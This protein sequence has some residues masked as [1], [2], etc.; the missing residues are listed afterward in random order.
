MFPESIDPA[1]ATTAF[2]VSIVTLV[3]SALA[4][5]IVVVRL[6]ADYFVA[7]RRTHAPRNGNALL[8]G[9]LLAL[10]SLLGA[11][12]VLLGIVMLVLPGQG[13][14]M[15]IAG[16]SLMRFPGK[17]KLLRRLLGAPGVRRV[18]N[19]IRKRAGKPP[20]QL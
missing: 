8:D 11:I 15:I 2:V 7:S 3:G 9:A 18:C 12:L 16:L 4:V 19:A 20:L 10:R 13:V 14:L 17:R 6:P 1:L 5:P